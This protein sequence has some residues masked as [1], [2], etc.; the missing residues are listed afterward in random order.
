MFHLA[1]QLYPNKPKIFLEAYEDSTRLPF[2]YI[3]VD[4]HSRSN[5]KFR[6]QARLTS[7]EVK[8]LGVDFSPVVYI[9]IDNVQKPPKLYQRITAGSQDEK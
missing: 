5:D 1:R 7:S 8:H 9:P 3:R 4:C 6:L 2:S